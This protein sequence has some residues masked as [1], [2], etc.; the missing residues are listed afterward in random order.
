MEEKTLRDDG[1]YFLIT[2]RD[3][4]LTNEQYKRLKRQISRQ[5][6]K[7]EPKPILLEGGITVVKLQIYSKQEKLTIRSRCG[8]KKIWTKPEA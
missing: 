5:W 2:P 4:I 1:L 8:G 7:D 6:P 3:I